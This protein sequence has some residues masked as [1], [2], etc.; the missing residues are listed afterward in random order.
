MD[1]PETMIPDKDTTFAFMRGA[2]A[3]GHDCLH[4]LPIEISNRGRNVFARARPIAVSDAPP[5]FTLGDDRQ[6]ELAGLDA[7]FVRKDPPFD[8]EYLHLTQQLDL[9]NDRTLVIN[10]ARG[11]R[12]ANEKLFA[13][14]FSELMPRSLVSAEPGD[15]LEFVREQGGKAV[16]KPIDGA[17]GR[18]VVALDL[19]DMNTRALIDLLTCEG[20]KLALVQEYLPAVRAGDKRVLLLDGEPLGAILRV[21]RPDDLRANIH[22]GGIVHSTELT[23]EE[24]ALVAEVGARLRRHGLWFV[25]LDLIGGRLIEVNVTSPTGIQELGRFQGRQPELDVIAWVEQRVA[26]WRTLAGPH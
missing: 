1:P 15:I 25:G 23:P 18:G 14:Q 12:D 11:L 24:S 8:D 4:C 17:G 22:V 5:H 3:R 9:V 26:E 6:V 2:R 20:K 10:D 7:V 19:A 16:L 13:F 21:P